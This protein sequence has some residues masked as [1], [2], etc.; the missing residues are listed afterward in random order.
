[1]VVKKDPPDARAIIWE[2]GKKRTTRTKVEGDNAPNPALKR[3][4]LLRKRKSRGWEVM[5]M[6]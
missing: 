6:L 2:G 3:K 5:H 1:V 4:G